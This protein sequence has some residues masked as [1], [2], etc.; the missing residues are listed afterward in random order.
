MRNNTQERLNR[1][2]QDKVQFFANNEQFLN[3]DLPKPLYMQT[4]EK[5]LFWINNSSWTY[6]ENCKSLKTE[7]LL[8]R[9][10]NTPPVKMSNT[11]TCQQERYISPLYRQIPDALKNLTFTD[12][13][14]RPFN[15]HTG[16]Y[17][18][19]QHGYRKKMECFVLHLAV[20]Q[21]I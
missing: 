12:I 7:K 14:L 20:T 11:C 9:F 16:D 18:R 2:E 6:C 13:T 19:L 21:C 8:P 5:L 17:E 4:A 3:H 10:E 1:Q 15:I